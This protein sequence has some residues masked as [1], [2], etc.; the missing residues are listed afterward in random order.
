MLERD[1][2]AAEFAALRT[3]VL[4]RPPGAAAAER[5]VRRRRRRGGLLGTALVVAVVAAV[6]VGLA[7]F[8]AS[9]RRVTPAAPEPAPPAAGWSAWPAPPYLALPSPAPPAADR[10]GT[11]GAVE[12]GIPTL[13]TVSVV[14]DQPLCP[15]ERI[16]VV[17]ATYSVDAAGNQRLYRTQVAFLDR[18]HNQL[19]LAYRI[20]PCHATIYVISGD[21]PVHETIPPLA[22]FARQA[23]SVYGPDGG[24][25]WVQETDAC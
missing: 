23:A 11:D 25:V 10:C 20:P 1:P 3:A 19:T 24:V 6:G 7:G 8:A 17:L 9:P 2:L 18:T 16:R 13:A 5:T 21:R 12:V 22:D 14:V 4:T 15:G